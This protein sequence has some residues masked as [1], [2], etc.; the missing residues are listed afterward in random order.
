MS[1]SL[2]A[3]L[4]MNLV[5]TSQPHSFPHSPPHA[6]QLSGQPPELSRGQRAGPPGCGRAPCTAV[7]ERG[8][9]AVLARS[10]CLQRPAGGP[11]DS[12]HADSR[13]LIL[14]LSDPKMGVR[15]ENSFLTFPSLG[16]TE[17]PACRLCLLPWAL[18]CSGA[19]VWDWLCCW[20]YSS[21]HQPSFT[22]LRAA[23]Y[24]QGLPL[25]GSITQ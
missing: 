16:A 1:N 25:G 5:L 10:P 3:Q 20:G 4:R 22:L 6:Q 13:G 7:A 9:A 2:V 14:F 11:E 24:G 8:P 23:L 18:A 21:G 17:V 15:Q 19:G 12:I